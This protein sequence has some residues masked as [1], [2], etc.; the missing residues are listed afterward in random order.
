[1]WFFLTF[2]VHSL[3][4]LTWRKNFQTIS[5][6]PILWTNALRHHHI[7]QYLYSPPHPSRH[8]SKQANRQ[9][10]KRRRQKKKNI[11]LRKIVTKKVYVLEKREKKK[12]F[13]DMSSHCVTKISGND[14]NR[15][16][17]TEVVSDFLQIELT[18]HKIWIYLSFLMYWHFP[19]KQDWR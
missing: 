10:S 3:L 9:W 17:Y 7:F 6:R 11:T 19:R 16:E 1:M 2:V 8:A 14:L 4:F 13:L 12:I 5:L 18:S 15:E